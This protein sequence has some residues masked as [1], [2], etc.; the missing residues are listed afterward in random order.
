MLDFANTPG[1]RSVNFRIKLFPQKKALWS[2]TNH[3]L[4]NRLFGGWGG[5]QVNKFE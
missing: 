2:K 1:I 4:A 5:P 3:P